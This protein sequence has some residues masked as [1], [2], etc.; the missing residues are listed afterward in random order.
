VVA[1]VLYSVVFC[2]VLSSRRL[3]EGF[4]KAWNAIL[5]GFIFI[6]LM[7]LISL[8]LPLIS[9]Q[10]TAY[11]GANLIV[12]LTVLIAAAFF[13]YGFYKLRK[14]FLTIIQGKVRKSRQI[15]VY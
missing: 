1:F 10:D 4:P 14:A 13:V 5:T 9:N 3:T 12:P 6:L 7:D 8:I 2:F 15:T 11:L